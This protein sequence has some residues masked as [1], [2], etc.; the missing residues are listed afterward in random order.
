MN[1]VLYVINL[2]PHKKW[3]VGKTKDYKRRMDQHLADSTGAAWCRK[4]A[5]EDAITQHHGIHDDATWLETRKT[6]ELMIEHGL[7]NVRGAEYCQLADFTVE[8]ATRMSYAAVHHLKRSDREYIEREF[9]KSCMES[10]NGTISSFSVSGNS[11]NYNSCTSSLSPPAK[12][13]NY[14]TIGHSNTNFF[15]SNIRPSGNSLVDELKS[16]RSQKARETNR[17][18]FMIFSE[19]TLNEIVNTMPRTFRDL[20]AIKGIGQVKLDDFGANVL[21]IIE[22]YCGEEEK[23]RKYSTTAVASS[24]KKKANQQSC[25]RCDTDIPTDPDKPFC[26]GCYRFITKRSK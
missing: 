5:S 13:N 18:P 23:K 24:I 17:A 19:E 16:W 4:Y 6:L 1:E 9:R 21:N 15:Q 26:Y 3:Y 8:D 11:S 2:N 25:R 20:L 7:N 12:L 22:T 14:N 10:N